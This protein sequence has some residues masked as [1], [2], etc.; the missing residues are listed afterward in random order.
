MTAARPVP[1]VPEVR[2]MSFDFS[3][4]I[5]AWWLGG[6]RVLTRNIDAMHMLF[7]EGERFF[8]RSVKRYLRD[9]T[10]PDLKARV[11]GFI[12]QE[13]MHGREHEAAF[14]LLDR[15]GIEYQSFLDGT[16]TT[17]FKRLEARLSP[18]TCLAVTCALEHMTAVLGEGAFTDPLLDAAHPTMRELALWHAAEEIEHKSVA[19]DVYRAM[20]GGYVRR[21]FGMGV[22]FA[23]LTWLWHQG[24]KHLLRQDGGYSADDMRALKQRMRE[25]GTDRMA[26]VRRAVLDYLRPGFHPDD[27][28]TA[29]L[30]QAY[31][32]G[33]A[34]A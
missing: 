16:G 13:V 2:R 12:G 1:V 25:Q 19:F 11:K 8:V 9:I 31:F 34:A 4:D 15:D 18:M 26:D 14:A 10:D 7:P 3:D 23:S 6:D 33:R 29:H 21:I 24:T 27:H 30:A 28:D 22:A 32:A 17:F 5:P 20:G